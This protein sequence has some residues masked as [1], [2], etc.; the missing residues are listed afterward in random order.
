MRSVWPFWAVEDDAL[1]MV[2][3]GEGADQGGSK[4][5]LSSQEVT[6]TVIVIGKGYKDLRRVDKD[7]KRV[8]F[9]GWSLV[10]HVE[11]LRVH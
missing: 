8:E 7:Q 4:G 11:F 6:E 1:L 5:L 2:P 10:L 3:N 9:L